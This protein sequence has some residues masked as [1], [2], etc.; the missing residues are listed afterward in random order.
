M[1]GVDATEMWSD[2]VSGRACSVVLRDRRLCSNGETGEALAER[3]LQVYETD[4]CKD[5]ALELRV[6][7]AARLRPKIVV[8][9]DFALRR[10]LVKKE[11]EMVE[12][13]Q[14]SKQPVMLSN[15]T[16]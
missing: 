14:T 3:A 2:M 5:T 9:P 4:G 10:R 1:E 12:P 13:C 16:T 15:D 11:A 7:S 6:G 8:S